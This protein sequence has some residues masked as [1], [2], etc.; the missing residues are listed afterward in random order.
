MVQRLFGPGVNLNRESGPRKRILLDNLPR[1]LRGFGRSLGEQNAVIVVVDNDDRDCRAFKQ[2]LMACLQQCD[3]APKTVFCLAIEEMEAWLLGDIQAVQTAYPKARK[4]VLERYVPDSICGT[5]EVLADA[6]YP[7]KA[8]GLK[9]LGYAVVGSRK[10]EWAKN[11]ARS[12][13]LPKF[14]QFAAA[15]RAVNGPRPLPLLRGRPGATL[16]ARALR[17]GGRSRAARD[18]PTPAC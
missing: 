3:P 16:P 4:N 11:I 17:R 18:R 12:P 9:R 13:N 6:L 10:Q 1:I 8:S 2:E 14:L 5:W 7:E 15:V